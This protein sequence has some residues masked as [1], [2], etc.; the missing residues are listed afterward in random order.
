LSTPGSAVEEV[1]G[2][3]RRTTRSIVTPDGVGLRVTLSDVGERYLAFA[4]DFMFTL[5]PSYCIELL[6]A[7]SGS[8]LGREAMLISAFIFFLVR[9]GYFIVF[10][11]RWSGITPG[12]RLFALRVIDRRGGPLLPGAVIVRN[13]SREVEFFF[14]LTLV[15]VSASWARSAWEVVAVAAWL[16]L[17]AL[18]PLFNRD[19]LRLGDLLGGT[20]VIAL[21]RRILLGDV[22]TRT[23]TFVFTPQELQLYGIK[24]LQVLEGVLREDGRPDRAVL[25]R[26]ICAR[27]CRRIG[28]PATIPDSDAAVFLADFYAAQRAF[29][30]TR[31]NLGD[32]RADKHHTASSQAAGLSRT[33]RQSD[34][35][36]SPPSPPSDRDR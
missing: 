23:H 10:E 8:L 19:H 3:V 18:L 15:A 9:T 22:A 7:V 16:V 21:P 20:I 17:M 5:I 29:L 13:L 31:R 36:R 25:A 2:R 34:R 1:L 32:V 4:A 27:I 30:E 28:R 33:P 35:H 11:L 14:P 24:E 12:K 6:G 26:E